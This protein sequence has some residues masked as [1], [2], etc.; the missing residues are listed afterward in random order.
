MLD[1]I[2][3]VI[4]PHTREM[5]EKHLLENYPSVTKE[6]VN[7]VLLDKFNRLIILSDD[8]NTSTIKTAK[9]RV[10]MTTYDKVK[11]IT[12][13]HVTSDYVVIDM[14]QFPGTYDII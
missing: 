10:E 4:T 14:F 12:N 5:I 8:R 6:H 1:L 7:Y 3:R 11:L 2:E 9:A 13:K